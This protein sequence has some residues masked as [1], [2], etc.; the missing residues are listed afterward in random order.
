MGQRGS[1]HGLARSR[2]NASTGCSCSG[3]AQQTS[4]SAEGAILCQQRTGRG[5]KGR[6]SGTGAARTRITSLQLFLTDFGRVVLGNR[7]DAARRSPKRPLMNTTNG[8]GRQHPCRADPG[9]EG[10]KA[11]HRGLHRSFN[12]FGLSASSARQQTGHCQLAFRCLAG[13]LRGPRRRHRICCCPGGL[14]SD[15]PTRRGSHSLVF[16]S[17]VEYKSLCPIHSPPDKGWLVLFLF[18]VRPLPLPLRPCSAPSWF[19]VRGD[20]RCN[21]SLRLSSRSLASPTLCSISS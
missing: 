16:S 21:P 18:F 20:Y 10:S 8:E 4:R 13:S 15:N 5:S 19:L 12:Q 11:C 17:L 7:Q 1:S 9:P 14:L 2:R 3:W 6:V